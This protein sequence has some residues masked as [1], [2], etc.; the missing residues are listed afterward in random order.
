MRATVR[1]AK[2]SDIDDILNVLSIYNFKVLN[3]MDSKP[4]DEDF[5]E[6]VT[7]YNSLSEID[8]RTA[9]VG[10]INGQLVGFTH[11]KPLEGTTA[12]TT[13]IIVKPEFRHTG[14]GKKLQL[15]RMKDAYRKGFEKL[16]TY[17]ETPRIVDWYIQNFG[18]EI[19]RTE[20]VH[21]RMHFIKLKD[22]VIWGVHYG[23]KQFGDLKVL[24]CDLERFFKHEKTEPN[25]SNDFQ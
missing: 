1:K 8:L 5:R 20:P 3:P 18:Y 15:A 10:V 17:C 13:F 12:K 19:D 2:K 22:K 14:L 7:L 16:I 4:L 11:Y 9:F 24:V 25:K 23:F 21:H 6:T